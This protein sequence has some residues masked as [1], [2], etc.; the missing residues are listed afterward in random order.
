MTLTRPKR[1]LLVDDDPEIRAMIV[2]FL[3]STDCEITEAPDVASAKDALS[4]DQSFDLAIIDFWLGKHH[5]VSIIDLIQ[6]DTTGVPVIVIS[7]G[8]GR[9]DL[10]KT[11][12]ISDVSGAIVFLQ[13]PFRKSDL[14][15]AV[16]S[17]AK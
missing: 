10:E 5:A 11:Q 1:I 15:N 16:A 3:A 14:L 7:G 2:A 9:M 6:C 13:K 8:N 17:S 12:A 4:S